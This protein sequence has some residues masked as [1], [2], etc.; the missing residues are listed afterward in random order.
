MDFAA[1]GSVRQYVKNM[2]LQV[3]WQNRQRTGNYAPESRTASRY[4]DG[5]SARNDGRQSVSQWIE[6][7][8]RKIQG[9]DEDKSKDKNLKSIA[10][11]LSRGER[12]T[13]SEKRYLQRKDPKTY[14]KVVDTELEQTYYA[15]QLRRCRTKDEVQRLKFARAAASVGTVN[16]VKNNP[17]ITQEKKLEIIAGEQMKAAAAERTEREFV[18]SGNYSSL[19]TESEKRFAEK[20]LAEA[21]RNEKRNKK[22]E[23]EKTVVME[24]PAVTEKDKKD[25]ETKPRTVIKKKYRMKRGITKAQAEQL[26]EVKKTKRAKKRVRTFAS[27]SAG[28]EAS[29]AVKSLDIKA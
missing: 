1:I 4:D 18:R 26:A 5:V 7:Q 22:D 6:E 10:E 19:P 9:G 20:K 17:H 16:S 3:K 27:G 11:K 25:A 23:F 21:E 2:N 24:E 12:L 28:L 13:A 14:Q 29:V 8:K 15:Q